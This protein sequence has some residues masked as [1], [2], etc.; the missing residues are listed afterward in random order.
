MQVRD[1]QGEHAVVV[2]VQQSDAV[3]PDEG[4]TI[5]FAG[6][7]DAL[8]EF[9]TRLRLFT[10]S[11]RDDDEG[12]CLLL[13]RQQF[14]IVGTELRRHHEDGQFGRGYLTGIVEGLDSLHFVFLGVY[15][16]QGSIVTATDQIAYNRA[17]GLMYVVRAADDD[18]ALWV[19]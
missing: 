19:Q 6:V 17:A 10:E 4:G 11:G 15:N 1:G 13:L 14:H 18:N 5:L 9:G 2:A 7:E 3:R 16:A 12:A 8:L